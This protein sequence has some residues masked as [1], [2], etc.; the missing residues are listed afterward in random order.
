MQRR[1]HQSCDD[2]RIRLHELPGRGLAVRFKD[3]DPEGPVQRFIGTTCQDDM[4]RPCGLH[5]AFEMPRDDRILRFR[6]GRL[7]LESGRDLQD[8]NILQARLDLLPEDF[9]NGQDCEN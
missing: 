9:A 4:S 1:G 2:C 5:Q 6:P 7:L 8:V 3:H